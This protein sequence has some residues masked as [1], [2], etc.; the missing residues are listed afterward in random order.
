MVRI[1]MGTVIFGISILIIVICL[2]QIHFSRH[3]GL[4]DSM[5]DKRSRMKTSIF[6]AT[7]Q[8]NSHYDAYNIHNQ[9][10][11]SILYCIASAELPDRID[12]LETLLDNALDWC[13]AGHS[14][15]IIIDTYEQR[16]VDTKALASYWQNTRLCHNALSIQIQE[17]VLPSADLQ[18]I[19]LVTRHRLHF[20]QYLKEKDIF[21][22]SEDDISLRFASL[23]Q[24]IQHTTFLGPAFTSQYFVGMLRYENAQMM[25]RQKKFRR[26]IDDM[27]LNF[28]YVQNINS[29][30]RNDKIE[31]PKHIPLNRILWELDL[32]NLYLLNHTNSNTNNYNNKNRNSY[33]HIPDN[34]Y[35]QYNHSA[36]I[37]QPYAAIQLFF[38]YQLQSLEMECQFLSNLSL[39]M[40]LM[41]NFPEFYTSLQVFNCG[42][43]GWTENT[44]PEYY[45]YLVGYKEAYC[46]RQWVFPTHAT[47]PSDTNRNNSKTS[48]NRNNNDN[49]SNNSNKN[50]NHHHHDHDNNG[51]ADLF[52]HHIGTPGISGDMKWPNRHRIVHTVFV[53]RLQ[54]KIRSLFAETVPS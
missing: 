1:G 53:A 31:M 28:T 20:H 18:K 21:I 10:K 38:P 51:L 9:Q 5:C 34:Y 45:R 48:S 32:E 22:F 54:E 30:N 27:A 2:T 36:T 6:S 41:T 33:D 4:S 7:Q 24:W 52:V 44:N 49:N 47:V 14:V 16:N 12:V 37:N 19:F 23:Q 50:S 25:L 42:R 46:C 17:H 39:G 29:K 40:Q 43:R 35:L 26:K 15:S 11:Y 13:E 8:M 3:E